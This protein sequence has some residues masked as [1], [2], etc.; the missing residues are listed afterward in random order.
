MRT[1]QPMLPTQA[2]TAVNSMKACA[3]HHTMLISSVRLLAAMA[4]DTAESLRAEATLIP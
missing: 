1:W 2:S 3:M 4:V